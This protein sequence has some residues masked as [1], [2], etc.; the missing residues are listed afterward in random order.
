MT[1]DLNPQKHVWKETRGEVGH[2]HTQRTAEL[3]DQFEKH[4]TSHV[5]SCSLLDQLGYNK[6]RPMFI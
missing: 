6:L 1:P 2:N 3:A 4:L 5:F